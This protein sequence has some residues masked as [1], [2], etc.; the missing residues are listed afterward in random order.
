MLKKSETAVAQ[1]S[2]LRNSML[3][4]A[5]QARCHSGQE[6]KKI[7]KGIDD[8][9]E[10]PLATPKLNLKTILKKDYEERDLV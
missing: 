5:T 1:A 3:Y 8:L 4:Y 2:N 6:I 9:E 10:L 7:E